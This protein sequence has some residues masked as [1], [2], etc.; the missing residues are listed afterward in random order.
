MSKIYELFGYPATDKSTDVQSSRQKIFCPF[1]SAVCDGG[2]NRFQ[3]EINLSAHPELQNFFHGMEKVP[4][5]ICSIQLHAGEPPWIICP[6]RLFY[7]GKEASSEI[8]RG[9]TQK[10]LLNKCGFS[11]NDRIGVWTEVKI[12]YVSNSQ[13]AAFDY[14]FDYILIPLATITANQ[15]V[16]LSKIPWSQLKRVLGENNYEIFHENSEVL[17]KNFPVGSPVIVEVMTSS[18]SGGNKKIRSTIPQAFED[19]ILG[20]ITSHP[21]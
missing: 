8:L 6:R 9:R 21:E 17:I 2:G 12:K 11:N 13:S 14:T 7:M 4:S 20:D 3:S 19:C 5:G 1:M 10:I 16:E 18:T 15:A